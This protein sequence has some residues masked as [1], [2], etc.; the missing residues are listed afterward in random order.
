MAK[1]EEKAM[2]PIARTVTL[3]VQYDRKKRSSKVV[4]DFGGITWVAGPWSGDYRGKEI[5]LWNKHRTY[6]KG[7]MEDLR[8][9]LPQVTVAPK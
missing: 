6:F 1:K 5:T 3:H 8:D 2:K 4:A 7:E 9:R